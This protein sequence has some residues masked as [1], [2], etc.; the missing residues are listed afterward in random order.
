MILIHYA[1]TPYYAILAPFYDI[2][3]PLTLLPPHYAIAITPLLRHYI[4]D[5]IRL[6]IIDSH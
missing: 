2:T 3:P 5:D 1:I 6:L 4:I